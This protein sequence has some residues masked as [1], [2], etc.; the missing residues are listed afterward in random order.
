MIPRQNPYRT[1]HA[2][3]QHD[4][5]AFEYFRRMTV[6]TNDGREVH[7]VLGIY[8][9]GGTEIQSVRFPIGQWTTEQ[10]E[11]WLR[12]YHKRDMVEAASPY[13]ADADEG[14]R[15]NPD[16]DDLSLAQVKCKTIKIPVDGA[17]YE[18]HECQKPLPAGTRAFGL[19]I[20]QHILPMCSIGCA[21][22][23]AKRRHG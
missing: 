7:F 1:E 11:D 5:W 9:G 16:G 19:S 22:G 2:A 21:F 12:R 23:H 6:D 13:G 4:P 10:A 3:R 14:L 20:G 8:P 18:C 17:K 15:M